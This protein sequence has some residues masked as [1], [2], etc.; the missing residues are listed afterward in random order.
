M[1]QTGTAEKT[2]FARF[3]K[4]VQID[5]KLWKPEVSSVNRKQP[6]QNQKF[7]SQTGSTI[8]EPEVMNLGPSATIK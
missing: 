3:E 4:V 7:H 6:K 2:D 5:I 1:R 8:S